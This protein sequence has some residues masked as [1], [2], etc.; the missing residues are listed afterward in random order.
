MGSLIKRLRKRTHLWILLSIF[1]CLSMIV[2]YLIYSA[3]SR[4]QVTRSENRINNLP[5][6]ERTITNKFSVM[7]LY[8]EIN[9][10]PAFPKGM[11]SCP[12]ANGTEY[13]L[14]FY[15]GETLMSDV[16]LYPTGCERVKLTTGEYKWALDR[17]FI[18]YSEVV[19]STL[20]LSI[21]D[22]YGSQNGRSFR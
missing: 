22:F 5:A 9:L 21:A 19:R 2:T 13:N 3:P 8:F 20:N 10:L 15:Q 12:A 6:M 16:V 17:K 14:A 1:M 11:I 18:N 7:R 4:L